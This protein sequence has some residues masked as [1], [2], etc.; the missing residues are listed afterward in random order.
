M[1]ADSIKVNCAALVALAIG[2]SSVWAAKP[3]VVPQTPTTEVG[4]KHETPC[5][6]GK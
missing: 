3:N 4:Q 2:A 6:V 5:T 1:R